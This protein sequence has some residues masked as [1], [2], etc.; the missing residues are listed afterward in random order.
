LY[1]LLW[2][3]VQVNRLF[4][5]LHATFKWLGTQVNFMSTFISSIRSLILFN[6]LGLH[7]DLR[8]LIAFK[9]DRESLNIAMFLTK[10]LCLE[11]SKAQAKLS[12]I[13]IS[14]A[15]NILKLSDKRRSD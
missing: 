5:F 9:D 8:T 15:E 6:T 1:H 7:K 2:W 14:S 10:L 12:F 13:A 3:T 11:K 4:R